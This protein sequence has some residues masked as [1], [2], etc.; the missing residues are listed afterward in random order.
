MN[1]LIGD[2]FLKR[3][4]GSGLRRRTVNP[5]SEAENPVGDQAEKPAEPGS[6]PEEDSLEKQAWQVMPTTGE[7][8]KPSEQ[9]YITMPSNSI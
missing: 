7:Q 6:F 5:T 2:R 1:S 8:T 9:S 4:F 3:F